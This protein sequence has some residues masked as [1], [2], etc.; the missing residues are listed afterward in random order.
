MSIEISLKNY[1]ESFLN[2]SVFPSNIPQP[3]T[4]DCVCYRRS[5]TSFTHDLAGAVDFQKAYFEIEIY[6]DSISTC[7]ELSESIRQKL[8]GFFGVLSETQVLNV[9]LEDESDSYEK[10]I[11]GKA[12]GK[13]VT[14]Q[15]YL[16]LFY[17]N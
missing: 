12:S 7:I 11:S 8:Q 4:A 13:F 10:P 6:S 3:Q 1:L 16:I 5:S 15:T 17:G 9:I 2:V 14:G